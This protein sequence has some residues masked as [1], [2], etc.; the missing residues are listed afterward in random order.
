MCSFSVL[1]ISWENCLFYNDF[2]CSH[3]KDEEKRKKAEC[4]LN[5]VTLKIKRKMWARV[6]AGEETLRLSLKGKKL[7]SLKAKWGSRERTRCVCL[8]W[9]SEHCGI[10]IFQA[11][12]SLH[13]F[14]IVFKL[15]LIRFK[16]WGGCD[17]KKVIRSTQKWPYLDIFVIFLLRSFPLIISVGKVCSCGEVIIASLSRA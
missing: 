5:L 6:I 8:L 4:L 2:K 15:N 17:E 11:S 9:E 10:Y 1:V 3:R 7:S 14:S 13:T 12:I 16:T